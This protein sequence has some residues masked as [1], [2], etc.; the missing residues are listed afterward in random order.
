M[1]KSVAK[2]LRLVFLAILLIVWI[3]A[4]QGKIDN[5]SLR[6]ESLTNCRI[7]Q[8]AMG[9]TCVP[10]NPQRVIALSLVDNVIAL[11]IKPLEQRLLKV[12]WIRY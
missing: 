5:S 10:L 6:N 3:A 4:C 8:H 12:V 9:E 1:S 7:I 2:S 11:G